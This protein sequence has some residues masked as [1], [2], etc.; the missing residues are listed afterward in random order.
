LTYNYKIQ[1]CLTGDYWNLEKTYVK[2]LGDVIEYLQGVPG[3]GTKQCGTI[4]DENFVGIADAEFYSSIDRSCG[5]TIHCPT[6]PPPPQVCDSWAIT[7]TNN[8]QRAPVYLDCNNEQ[9]T[10]YLDPNESVTVCAFSIVSSQ[11]CLTED[12]GSC[13]PEASPTPTPTVSPSAT[14]AV[15]GTPIPSTTPTATASSTPTPTPSHTPIG[16]C[17]QY[18][19]VP[20]TT[21]GDDILLEYIDCENNMASIQIFWTGQV[22]FICAKEITSWN[23]FGSYSP[24]G[25]SCVTVTPSPTPTMTPT[26]TDAPPSP[27]TTPTATATSTATATPIPSTTPTMTATA[28]PSPSSTPTATASSTPT[29][30][31]TPSHTSVSTCVEYI[32]VAPTTSGDD[33]M[34]TYID[35]NNVEQS[36][37]LFWNTSDFICA[38]SITYW[39][40]F[41]SYYPSG[42][43]C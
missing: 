5:D 16:L 4:V 18:E 29:P 13:F 8:D 33:L 2:T 28:T 36:I 9:Q 10:I 32:L 22:D 21:S 1:D 25:G 39:N 14:P 30:T 7:N 23:G 27:S 38:K 34:I 43:Y 15:S 26:P 35:C 24:S 12:N 31:P 20:P 3:S 41:G 40:G 19:V 11:G 42:N 37:Q 17:I 6:T